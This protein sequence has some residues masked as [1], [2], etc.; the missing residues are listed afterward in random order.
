MAGSHKTV[1]GFITGLMLGR[2]EE[3]EVFF[4]FWEGVFHE[5]FPERLAEAVHLLPED[6]HLIVDSKI[7]KLVQKHAG[8]LEKRLGLRIL[9]SRYIRSAHFPVRF[10]AF[11]KRYD[12]EIMGLLKGLPQGVRLE[13]FKRKKKLHP[14]AQGIEAYAAAHDFEVKGSGKV[15]GRVDV[16]IRARHQLDAHPLIKVGKIRLNMA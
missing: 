6:C 16:V 5:K 15:T 8:E 2:Q 9:S 4:H 10:Q 1:R 13:D 14:K 3:G 12:V 11:A 7:R